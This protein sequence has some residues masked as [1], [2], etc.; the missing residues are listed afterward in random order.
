MLGD[1]REHSPQRNSS[2]LVSRGLEMCI[3]WCPL[4]FSKGKQNLQSQRRRT[5]GGGGRRGM[6]T[7][8]VLSVG[9]SEVPSRFLWCL[10]CWLGWTLGTWAIA[11]CTQMC[12]FKPPQPP[13]PTLTHSHPRFRPSKTM[14]RGREGTWH[15]S[16]SGENSS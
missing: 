1:S 10:L 12:P 6:Q 5:K 7:D 2:Y 8:E 11:E 13:L 14:Q 3:R 16:A 4:A 9:L 15:L